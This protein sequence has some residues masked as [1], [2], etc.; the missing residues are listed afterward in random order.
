M[1]A[2]APRKKTAVSLPK[3]RFVTDFPISELKENSR[4]PRRHSRAQIEAIA[5]SIDAFGFN[6]PVLIDRRKR[7]VAGHGRV[8][9]ARLRGQTHVPAI[10]LEHLTD[11]KA[12]AYLL[13]DN[14]LS[15]RSEWDERL[16]AEHLKELSDIALN[17]EI[18]ATGFEIGE[19]DLLIQSLDDTEGVAANDRD[20][21]VPAV[22]TTAVCRPGDVWELGDHRIFCGDARLRPSYTTL[23]AGGRAASV[24]SDPPY[25]VKI[26]GNV[27]GLGRT[28]HREFVMASGELS[29]H[30][31]T[32]FLTD[33]FKALCAGSSLGSIHFHCMD[34]RHMRE[35]LS[36]G[37]AAYS[38]LVN[39]C[40]WAKTNAGMGSLYRSRH[41]LIFAYKNGRAPHRNNVQLGRFGR[42]RTNVWTYP[43]ASNFGGRG[44]N[45]NVLELHP[46]V[47]PV[48]LV[49]DAIRDT[50]ARGDIV[51]DP[52]LG[53]G[54]TIIAAERTGRRCFGVELDPLYVDVAVR[55]W[56]KRTGKPARRMTSR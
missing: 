20:D 14:K 50:T 25:N 55:R 38:E 9:A 53:S 18:E 23:L 21:E 35:I 49:A 31:F 51:L 36:A 30:E 19:I 42:T 4:N 1:A 41:E 8:A 3:S 12:K 29:R 46:T 5:R 27:S 24:F 16:L 2:L 37:E 28:R 34:W 47:K 52:F 40:V 22:E 48:A 45:E 54:T 17:F 56:Q 43:G 13:A 33:V 15:D 44:G 7:L 39:L 26:G 10:R 6:A 32:Q 11:A